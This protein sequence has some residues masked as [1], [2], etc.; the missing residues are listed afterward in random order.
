MKILLRTA[1]ALVLFF[2]PVA[3]AMADATAPLVNVPAQAQTVTPVGTVSLPATSTSPATSATVVTVPVGDWTDKIVPVAGEI[4]AAAIASLVAWAFRELPAAIQANVS[5]AQVKQATD[6]LTHAADYGLNTIASQVQGK[7]V[8][9]D[10]GNAA[11]AVGVQYVIDH[12]PAWAVGFMGGPEAIKQK[13]IAR[14]PI[15]AAASVSTAPVVAAH[16]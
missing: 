4:L 10:V 8:S 11:A 2:A 1:F 9:L 12:G 7:T 3:V 14:L 16:S 5:A 6:L 13:I 15:S